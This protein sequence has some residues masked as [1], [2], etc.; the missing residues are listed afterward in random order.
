MPQVTEA[1]V[2]KLIQHLQSLEEGLELMQVK[3]NNLRQH[4]KERKAKKKRKRNMLSTESVLT[5]EAIKELAATKEAAQKAKKQA[6]LT[7]KQ[8]KEGHQ[9]AIKLTKE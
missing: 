1:V 2:L 5:L 7:R 9:V 8:L 4:I 3:N 6:K